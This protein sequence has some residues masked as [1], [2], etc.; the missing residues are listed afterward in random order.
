MK[1]GILGGG[2]LARMMALA[3]Y[4]MGIHTLCLDPIANVCAADVTKVIQ[5]D[6]TDEKQLKAFAEQVDVITFET[7]NIPLSTAEWVNEI[8]PI[9]PTLEALKIGQDRWLEKNL[10][11]AL[12]IPTP[13]FA[14]INNVTELEQAVAKIGLPAVLKTRRFGYDGKGQLVLKQATDMTGAWEKLGKQALILEQFI[15]FERELSLIAVR[16]KNGNIQF[17]PLVEN[18]HKQ[19]ILQ[20]SQA[21][22]ENNLLQQKAE[23]YVQA[24][25]NKLNY[26]GTFVIELFQ[27]GE[28]LLANEMAPR[29]HNSGHWTIEGAVTC[30][31]ANHLRAICGLP[32][33]S[34]AAKGYSAMF[35]IIGEYPEQKKIL[36]IPEAHYHT[37]E[38]QAKPKRKLGHITIN[39]ADKAIYE[40]RLRQLQKIWL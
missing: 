1:V 34:T 37:Y 22:F 8:K 33:G 35:N 39:V 21:P 32:L 5:A 30:Q 11:K 29:V 16:E 27:K 20:L 12:C 15:P 31:F 18:L 19:G 4:S 14:A 25:L 38:K 10:F 24:I 9:Y 23:G 2:Q 40:Q 13:A 36:S 17:Y 7:E 3:G 28:E 6:F 26:V